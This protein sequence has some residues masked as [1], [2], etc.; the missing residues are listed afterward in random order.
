MILNSLLARWLT[1]L[2]GVLEFT[3]NDLVLKVIQ[4]KDE[5]TEIRI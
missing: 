1:P 3:V 2:N 4:F 5:K